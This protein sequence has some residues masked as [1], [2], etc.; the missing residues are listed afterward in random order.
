MRVPLAAAALG[1][2]LLASA[3]ASAYCRTRTVGVAP[4]YDAV[5]N[6]CKED[7]LPL[8]WLNACVG[9]SITA[10]GSKKISYD[11][12]ANNLS[13]AFTRWTGASCPAD[14]AGH[15]RPSIDVRD[16]GPVTCNKVEYHGNVPN[17]NLILFRDDSWTHGDKVLGLTTVSYA[18]STGEIYGADMEL[19]TYGMDPLKVQDP[20]GQ[21]D[22]DFLS[23]VTHEAGHFL[24]MGHSNVEQSTMYASYRPGQTVQRDL[25]PDDIDGICSIYRPD[26]T[27]TVLNTQVSV[28]PQCD[29]TP[30]GGYTHEC[31]EKPGCTMAP[32]TSRTPLGLLGVVALW[33]RRRARRASSSR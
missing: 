21:N 24:G 15:T 6:G 17:Q 12:A 2:A 33:L 10:A 30:R 14:A 18:P 26:G 5:Q 13:Q 20:V 7:G 19:N 27:R 8:F 16:L 9:Y 32:A 3:S 22:Y 29:P 4:D 28:A 11:D 25:R 23:V 1:V 31:Y